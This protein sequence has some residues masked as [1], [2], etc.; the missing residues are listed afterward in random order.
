MSEST[1][2]SSIRDETLKLM[3]AVEAERSAAEHRRKQKEETSSAIDAEGKTLWKLQD[4]GGN[5]CGI[6]R[7]HPEKAS[8][9]HRA[10]QNTSDI[11]QAHRQ[12]VAGCGLK[13]EKAMERA[14]SVSLRGQ[15]N[16]ALSSLADHRI[17]LEESQRLMETGSSRDIEGVEDLR[18]R[19]RGLCKEIERVRKECQE[20]QAAFWCEREALKSDVTRY[21]AEAS[22]NM[23]LA[24]QHKEMCESLKRDIMSARNQ[25]TVLEAEMKGLKDDLRAGHRLQR[26]LG[27]DDSH[28]GQKIQRDAGKGMEGK[29]KRKLAS[30]QDHVYALQEELR[31]C[32]VGLQDA[33]QLKQ[34]REQQQMF[35]AESERR[36][37][38]LEKEMVRLRG[39]LSAR[40][41]TAKDML[42]VRRTLET[43]VMQLGA[44]LEMETKQL[45]S[46]LGERDRAL[47][48]ASRA[49]DSATS[50]ADKL[51]QGE[52]F[53]ANKLSE[54]EGLTSE[55]FRQAEKAR[56]ELLAEKERTKKALQDLEKAQRYASTLC[57]LKGWTAS[58]HSVCLQRL[59]GMH[60]P[61]VTEKAKGMLLLC[62][63]EKARWYASTLCD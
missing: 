11:L 22:H 25:V 20:S 58:T 23:G 50:M 47:H 49:R 62:V 45:R 60:P 13:D 41:K 56:Q 5:F 15:L 38:E 31:V 43:D 30:C 27:E 8:E 16:A 55:N 44:A 29:L 34:E 63:F 54:M 53:L 1:S 21:R 9:G 33:E 59:N 51:R 36:V 6:S 10:G 57:V 3:Q 35:D 24:N 40:D 61:F 37:V 18:R 52:V 46:A 32:K 17:L 12:G 28:G 14:E 7:L 4:S 48:D 42:H 39:M 2:R 26:D 19:E